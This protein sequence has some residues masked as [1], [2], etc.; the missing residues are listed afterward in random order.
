MKIQLISSLR[1]SVKFL[2][3]SKILLI[4]AFFLIFF[5]RCKPVDEQVL[6]IK[7]V[8]F[9]VSLDEAVQVAGKYDLTSK[10]S[11][12]SKNQGLKRILMLIKRKLLWMRIKSLYFTF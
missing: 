1:S 3:T 11:T 9:E 10:K 2:S 8:P 7:K 12:D 5:F 6:E 4:L